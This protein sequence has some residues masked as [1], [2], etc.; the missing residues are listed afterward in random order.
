MSAQGHVWVKGTVPFHVI[1]EKELFFFPPK[2]F[3]FHSVCQSWAHI[4]NNFFSPWVHWTWVGKRPVPGMGPSWVIGETELLW[5]L[6]SFSKKVRLFQASISLSYGLLLRHSPKR[7]LPY[8]IHSRMH[9]SL[10]CEHL[11]NGDAPSFRV[12]VKKLSDSQSLCFDEV[13]R[14]PFGECLSTGT[15]LKSFHKSD[16]S[17][18]HLV[19]CSTL[20]LAKHK[21][22]PDWVT[23]S[24]PHG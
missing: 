16:H 19:R 22:S 15:S 14:W 21:D 4:S 8:S 17:P 18:V 3:F 23:C 24:R 12:L 7:Q 6:P 10:A 5:Y 1:S 20:Y 13:W 2:H 11:G 9:T